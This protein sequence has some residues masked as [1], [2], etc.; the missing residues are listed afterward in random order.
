MRR[1]T[2]LK[3]MAAL[4][5]AGTLPLAARAAANLKMMIPANPGGGWDSTGRALGKALQEAGGRQR[6]LREQGRRRRR[7]RAGAVRQ[8]R[9]GDPNALMV[10]GAGH[11]RRHHHR[12]AAGE[13]H[14]VHA[15]GPPDQRVQRAFV[16]P[17]ASAAEDDE[18]CG[19]ADEEG[20]GQRQVGRRLA[21]VH[22]AHHDR[23]DRARGRCRRQRRSTT[24]PSV[25]AARPRRPSWATTSPWVA[26]ATA[27]SS[28]TSRAARCARSPWR[29]P[30]RQKGI[31]V[32]TLKEQGINVEL[33]N[34][35]GVY[36]APGITAAQRARR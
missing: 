13:H 16:L 28:S 3:S 12:Q 10:M 36:G 23:D 2:F 21:R 26:A 31:A 34:W 5:A 11:A 4:A 27:S 35:R 15:D 9:K 8:R 6:D 25:A 24:C 18:G 19:R 14:A 1:D 22:R 29:H 17:A 7:D 32:P 30:A 33:G 20:P